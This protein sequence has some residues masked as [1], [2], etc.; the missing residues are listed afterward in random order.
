MEVM[1]LDPSSYIK[2][3]PSGYSS[4]RVSFLALAANMKVVRAL[5]YKLGKS[6]G[7]EGTFS[8]C[9]RTDTGVPVLGLQISPSINNQPHSLVLPK[10][11]V[12]AELRSGEPY[13]PA[14][15]RLSTRG[16][17]GVPNVV[18]VGASFRVIQQAWQGGPRKRQKSTWFSHSNPSFF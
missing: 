10:N 17:L 18:D 7:Q 9:H 8:V 4:S 13:C 11:M 3:H 5:Q 1:G 12:L 15:R 14:V 2:Q 6:S 16:A